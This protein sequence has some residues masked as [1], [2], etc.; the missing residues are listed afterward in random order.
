MEEN[1]DSEQNTEENQENTTNNDIIENKPTETINQDTENKTTEDT[2]KENK[3]KL[4]KISLP[5]INL[6]FSGIKNIYENQ[7][8]KLLIIPITLLLI[9][10]LLIGI[11][12]ATTG[13]FINRDVSLKGG[14]TVTVTT[15]QADILQLENALSSKF[16]SIIVF[17]FYIN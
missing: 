5:K 11:K 7:Y 3:F 17:I 6:N 16:P 10:I 4:P 9:A 12:A 15:E 8:K 2:I 1:K 14:V 13:D